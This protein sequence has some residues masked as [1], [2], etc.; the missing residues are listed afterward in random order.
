MKRPLRKDGEL[1]FVPLTR[2]YEAVVNIADFEI[3][4]GFN[5]F[6]IVTPH[7]VYAARRDGYKTIYLHRAISMAHKGIDVDHID[8][9]GLNNRRENIR[10]ANRSQNNQNRRKSTNNKSG[11]KGVSFCKRSSKWRASI[12]ID[13]KYKSLGYF[14]EANKAHEAYCAASKEMHG[15]FGRI[16]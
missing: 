2:G 3:V 5:W 11:Y 4:D 10:V 14:N 8:C 16:E 13:G 15:D 7:S 9:D 12:K 6:S 1:I